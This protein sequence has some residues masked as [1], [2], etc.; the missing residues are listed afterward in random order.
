[1]PGNI[2]IQVSFG[3]DLKDLMYLRKM[4][5]VFIEFQGKRSVKDMI[6]SLG[7]PHVEV[8]VILSNG[9]PVTFSYI[10][11]N[12]DRIAVF[13]DGRGMN[14]PKTFRL[15][16]FSTPDDR[17][18]CDDH[19]WKLARRLRLLG[20][21]AAYEADVS[22]AR[23]TDISCTEKRILLTRDRHVLMLRNVHRGMLIRNNHCEM[24]VREVL[25]RMTAIRL[26]PFSRCLIC[27]GSL[28]RVGPSPA[29]FDRTRGNIPPKVLGWC[30]EF[31][32]CLSCGK[33]YWKGAHFQRLSDFVKKFYDGDIV[34]T[35]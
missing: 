14:V 11:G 3:D 23:F 18:I 17:F 5:P 2:C 27:N 20:L 30:R 10:V 28:E 35:W 12:G 13:S 1:M 26:K 32:G 25:D 9:E 15:R 34:N 31:K 8:D 16:F 22:N 7:I 33:V 24:Q 29:S 6:E 19:L 4:D 21:D